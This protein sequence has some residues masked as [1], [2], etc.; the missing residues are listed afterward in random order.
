MRY[1]ITPVQFA[2]KRDILITERYALYVRAQAA[3]I[4]STV[5][6]QGVSAANLSS[7][8]AECPMAD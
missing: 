7:G 4:K 2:T 1:V 5:C 8:Y 6:Q 3:R